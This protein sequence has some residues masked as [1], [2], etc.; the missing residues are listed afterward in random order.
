M[1][2][3]VHFSAETQYTQGRDTVYAGRDTVYAMNFAGRTQ[4]VRVLQDKLE[5]ASL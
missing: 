3:I 4:L 2:G 5:S 1:Q